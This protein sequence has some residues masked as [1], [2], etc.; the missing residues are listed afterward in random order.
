MHLSF[1]FLLHGHEEICPGCLP[2]RQSLRLPLAAGTR[3]RHPP[4]LPTATVL[5]S[6]E[7][8]RS[9]CRMPPCGALLRASPCAAACTS[10]VTCSTC[11]F[12]RDGSAGPCSS[13]AAAAV[14]PPSMGLGQGRGLG[15]WVLRGRA[16]RSLLQLVRPA[17]LS[18]VF[19]CAHPQ[20]TGCRRRRALG[21]GSRRRRHEQGR[22]AGGCRAGEDWQG[23]R[24]CVY[25]MSGA[26]AS[27]KLR[28]KLVSPCHLPAAAAAAAGCAPGGRSHRG[29]GPPDQGV[30]RGQL[31][32]CC[33]VRPCP[34]AVFKH[35]LS[36]MCRCTVLCCA[37]RCCCRYYGGEESE[38][39]EP[40]K[41]RWWIF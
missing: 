20:C 18:A 35:T 41:K 8:R 14:G 39:T 22:G 34:T 38:P 7:G 33:A 11:C 6:V 30:S 16:C 2:S 31:K 15:G 3:H 19:P 9:A 21:G 36:D 27:G 29:G 24:L 32:L 23:E 12:A 28:A 4:P 13:A 40:A 1:S 26:L 37:V 5:P 17:S 25:V 10:S